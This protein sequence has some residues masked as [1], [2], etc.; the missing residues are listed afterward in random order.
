MTGYPWWD[1]SASLRT[2]SSRHL[3]P[4]SLTPQLPC[5]GEHCRHKAEPQTQKDYISSVILLPTAGRVATH[6]LGGS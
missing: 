2:G 5:P 3:G 1:I 6:P 4:W